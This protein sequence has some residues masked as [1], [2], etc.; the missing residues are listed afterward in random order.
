[1]RSLQY[2]VEKV[3]ESRDGDGN[4]NVPLT[5]GR[6]RELKGT[7]GGIRDFLYNSRSSKIAGLSELSTTDLEVVGMMGYLLDNFFPDGEVPEV[8]S[9]YSR[10]VGTVKQLYGSVYSSA[11]E[12]KLAEDQKLFEDIKAGRSRLTVDDDIGVY[13]G[14][15]VSIIEAD[16]VRSDKSRL[17]VLYDGQQLY[18]EDIREGSFAGLPN[19]SAVVFDYTP[20]GLV[21]NLRKTMNENPRTE[22][23][24]EKAVIKSLFDDLKT[25]SYVNDINAQI[26]EALG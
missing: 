15:L 26:D 24:V 9:E 1:M 10:I 17:V 14:S 18:E 22:D 3:E 19:G 11:L 12:R 6:L 16:E 4:I 20:Q 23:R 13:A 2:I 25:K 8:L 7:L 21:L 5:P